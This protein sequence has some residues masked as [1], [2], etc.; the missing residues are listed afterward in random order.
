MKLAQKTKYQGDDYW[1]WSVWI[2]GGKEELASVKSVRYLL[3]P[4][5]KPPTRWVEDRDEIPA[6]LIGFGRVYNWADVYLFNK[7]VLHL[8][9]DLQLEYPV[10]KRKKRPASRSKAAVAIEQPGEP[11]DTTKW[12]VVQ[13]NE[14]TLELP[15]ETVAGPRG[16]ITFIH[17]IANKP[18]AESL[19][20]LW[21]DALS[22]NDGIDL[23]AKGVSVSMV[24]WEDVLYAESLAE[25]VFVEESVPA[26]ES[27]GPKPTAE[28]KRTLWKKSAYFV[29]ALESD[30]Q[31]AAMKGSGETDVGDP[32]IAEER[33][34]V[35]WFVKTTADGAAAAGPASLSVQRGTQSPPG[36]D[37]SR[38]GRDSP[39]FRSER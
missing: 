17:G 6:R 25:A 7:E 10:A 19:L 29:A 11:I 30:F 20:K 5:F 35:P 15:T 34:W 22:T 4:T 8:K 16:H 32:M 33:I 24:Y 31:A 28:W 37:I 36:R 18:S 27:E 14:Q 26:S 38:A 39:A 13:E 1:D 9:H 2:D 23:K 21:L 12:L 3:H